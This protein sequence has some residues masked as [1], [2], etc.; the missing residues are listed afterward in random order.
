MG[1]V[2]DSSWNPV[3]SANI[4]SLLPFSTHETE[5]RRGAAADSPKEVGTSEGK[6]PK[7]YSP[8]RECHICPPPGLALSCQKWGTHHVLHYVGLH[9]IHECGH[10]LSDIAAQY[11]EA[12]DGTDKDQEVGRAAK[13]EQWEEG[14]TWWS[15]LKSGDLSF[16]SGGSSPRATWLTSSSWESHHKHETSSI[17]PSIHPSIL[18]FIHSAQIYTATTVHARNQARLGTQG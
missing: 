16:Y 1:M 10:S 11:S 15:T 4:R 6:V 8:P 12:G 7:E 2:Y 9:Q 18:P 3:I 14:G 13:E 17:H 5:W